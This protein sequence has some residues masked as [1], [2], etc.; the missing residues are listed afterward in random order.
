MVLG[1]SFDLCDNIVSR[2]AAFGVIVLFVD[3][4]SLIP[5]TLRLSTPVFDEFIFYKSFR[6]DFIELVKDFLKT[7]IK[8]E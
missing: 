5:R 3:A 6:S 8:N 4:I 1:L 7:R 2:Y